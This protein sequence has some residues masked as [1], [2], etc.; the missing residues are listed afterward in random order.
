MTIYYNPYNLDDFSNRPSY[1]R[2]KKVTGR[3][4]ADLIDQIPGCL[5]SELFQY[6]AQ[7]AEDQYWQHSKRRPR[8]RAN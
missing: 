7:K 1:H 6:L 8:R 3:F 5:G 2:F 4:A